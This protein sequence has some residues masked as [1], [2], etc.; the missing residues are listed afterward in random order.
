MHREVAD[1]ANVTGYRDRD[2]GG[3]M[4]VLRISDNGVG[5]PAGVDTGAPSSLGLRI[6]NTLVSQLHGVLVVGTGP[7]ASFTL[8]FPEG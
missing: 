5:L 7:G 2:G 8:T 4:L 3:R 6:V 1:K